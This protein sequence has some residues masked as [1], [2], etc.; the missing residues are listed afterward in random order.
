[1]LHLSA[2][3]G[4]M[5][6]GVRSVIKIAGHGRVVAY[7]DSD[8]CLGPGHLDIAEAA[9]RPGRSYIAGRKCFCAGAIMKIS[10]VWLVD[11]VHPSPA[12]LL[13]LCPV[14][15][16]QRTEDIHIARLHFVSRMRRET[17][18]N[19]AVSK[20]E[21]ED[22]QRLVDAETIA[23]QQTWP[24]ARLVSSLRIEHML[25]SVQTDFCV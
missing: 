18:K 14:C 11:V 23:D 17:T 7:R 24:T 6:R 1:M 2:K 20:A 15:V 21:F 8:L 13:N 19:D 3:Q 16:L 25:H 4:E 22:L 12:C 10:E 9:S 5:I